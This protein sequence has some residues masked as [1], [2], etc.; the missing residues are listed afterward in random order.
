LACDSCH[1]FPTDNWK[2]VRKD[3]AAF[4][5]VAE[6]P[7]HDSC[8][9]CHR[10]Q[11][12]ARERP[13]PRICANCHVNV[14]P[15]NTA[16][17]LFPS[18]GDIPDTSRVK[19]D[20]TP[21]FLINFSHEKHVEVVGLN[22]P[23][24]KPR[25]FA[26]MAIVWQEK[27]APAEASETKSC[28]VC[29]QTHQPQGDS[30]NEY[31][32]K[33]PK[34]LGDN[35]WLKK[36]TFKTMPNS[37]TGCFTCHNVEAGLAPAPSDCNA[38]HKLSSESLVLKSDFDAKLV[39]AMMISD[40]TILRTWRRRASSGTY[41]HEGGEHPNISCEK[42]HNV[43]AMDTTDPR[44]LRVPVTSCGGAEGCH[45]TATADDGGILNFEIDQKKAS[46]SFVCPKCQVRRGKQAI[47]DGH[48]KRIQALKEP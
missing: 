17:Y 13:A 23:Q 35:F 44:T 43:M 22:A 10:Q 15:R 19:A 45:V 36:G 9:K 1:K 3:D 48:L 18:L 33:P 14:T 28:P 29:H 37:H 27:K 24:R 41:R 39:Q 40:Q 8:L 46:A 6:F 21:E 31:A 7:Q 5:D 16:R 38:C 42:C 11:F 2:D 30:D 25:P 34:D 20:V 32:T 12:F 47:P 4:P 26:F